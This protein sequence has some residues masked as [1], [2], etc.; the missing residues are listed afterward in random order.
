MIDSQLNAPAD[1]GLH[2]AH[3]GR[4]GRH[5]GNPALPPTESTTLL[6]ADPPRKHG[7]EESIIEQ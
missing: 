7:N 2:A 1:G 3:R 5:Q 4:L 6:G